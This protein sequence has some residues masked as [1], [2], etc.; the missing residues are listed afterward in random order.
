MIAGIL[1]RICHSYLFCASA[2][3]AEVTS[4]VKSGKPGNP[5]IKIHAR[6]AQWDEFQG[7]CMNRMK[8]SSLECFGITEE[9]HDQCS[10][11]PRR[12]HE[13]PLIYLGGLVR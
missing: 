3:G 8:L 9:L 6:P 7:F 4:Q 2:G 10:V 13:K 1:Q 5:N 12:L 11:S